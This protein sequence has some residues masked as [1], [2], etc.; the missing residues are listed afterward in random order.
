M[1][2]EQAA[3]FRDQLIAVRDS[4]ETQEVVDLR[5]RDRD[6]FGL[7]REGGYLQITVLIVRSGRLAGSRGF[8]FS[9]QGIPDG[10]IL[11]TVINLLYS[12]GH[13]VPDEVIVPVE[14]DG[15]GEVH[16]EG[17]ARCLVYLVESDA[18]EA[19]PF[20]TSSKTTASSE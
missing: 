12:G 13:P 2:Y 20:E 15:V 17:V 6:V 8:D 16:G 19:S 7:Y 11:S 4:L 1:E 10:H 3:R 14:P 9:R 5:E 18:L